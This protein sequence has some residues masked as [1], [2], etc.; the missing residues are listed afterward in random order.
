MSCRPTTATFRLLDTYVGWDVA[1]ST[2]LVG[3]DDESGVRLERVGA[4][5][6]TPSD[7]WPHIPPPNLAPGCEPCE[8]YLVTP[9]PGRLLRR[10]ACSDGFEPTWV[11]RY[12]PDL[13]HRPVAVASRGDLVA[14]ADA[15][16]GNVFVWGRR[17]EQLLAEIDIASP[18]AVGISPWGAV[19]VATT[20]SDR[21][22][23]YDLSGAG[24]GVVDT[25]V[26][27]DITGIG[28][29]RSEPGCDDGC[30]TSKPSV[31][32]APGIGCDT[33]LRSE[34]EIDGIARVRLWRIRRT[35]CDDE[36]ARAWWWRL[37][38]GR[39]GAVEQTLADLTRSV[40]PTAL[41]AWS[42]VGFCLLDP[43]PDRDSRC[44]DRYGQT[45]HAALVQAVSGAQFVET[46]HLQTMPLDSGV[47][48]CRWHRVRLDATV[49]D[50]TTIAVS[51]ATTEDPSIP[52]FDGDWYHAP[53]GTID[54]LVQQPPGRYLA[55]RLR[56][57]GD[58]SSTP[59]IR[60]V[61]LDLPRST[62]LERLP[63]V[64]R[65]DPAA[66]DFTERFLSIFD[67]SI[68]DLDRHITRY[69]ALLDPDSVPDDVLGWLGRLLAVTFAPDWSSERRRRILRAAPDLYRRRGTPEGL[70]RAIRL[71]FDV[72]PVI[73][74]LGFAKPWGLLGRSAHLEHT[75]LFGRSTSRMRLG[76]SRLSDAPLRS[77]GD[78]RGDPLAAGAY[79][80]EV[81]VP[82]SADV[83]RLRHLVATITPAH[84]VA[85][86]RTGSDGFVVGTNSRIGVDT[87]LAPLP[88][89]VLGQTQAATAVLGRGS[90]L[91][92]SRRGPHR[93]LRLDPAVI[94]GERTALE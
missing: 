74:E 70:S 29:G 18:T 87:A 2:G 42:T 3:F 94:V 16:S 76:T 10:D 88:A 27:G 37:R 46:G 64:Y 63:D 19:V 35:E 41:A 89:P 7:V 4:S 51:V 6:I 66:E 79:R 24:L 47:P 81:L 48:R 45:L 73:V 26:V 55:V 31:D 86:V 11:S 58:G 50:G 61:R 22:R 32:T 82:T 44:Y 71:V 33:W 36:D 92:G 60:R 57:S 14:V 72:D 75:R 77:F 9:E 56:L 43:Q 28:F 62:T 69:P 20:G 13:L 15:D 52:I 65:H 83:A 68:E 54:F 23:W 21:L 80:I 8:W 49:P 5:G 84:V 30:D 25:G 17:G 12:D 53:A 91:R 78:P 59:D 40:A 67:A 93:G 34:V 38:S 39:V 90:V 1:F 85:D